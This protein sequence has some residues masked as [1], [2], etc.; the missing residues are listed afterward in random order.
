MAKPKHPTTNAIR[1]LKERV[2][3]FEAIPY[4]YEPRGGTRSSAA[5]LGVDEHLMIKT[6]VMET[7]QGDPLIVLMHGD[8]EV[9]TKKLAR[10]LCVKSIRPCDPKIANRHSGYFVGGTSPFGTRRSMPV[11]IQQT[12]LDLDQIYINAGHRG[13]M[14]HMAAADIIKALD[15]ITPVDVALSKAKS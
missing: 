13:L 15:S 10:T 14:L 2:I 5:T 9:S 1:C 11:Y 4:K 3:P 8:R 12:I 6:L 7:D